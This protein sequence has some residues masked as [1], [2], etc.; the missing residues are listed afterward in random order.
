MRSCPACGSANG[1]NDDFCGNCGS[2]LGWSREPAGGAGADGQPDAGT[3][4][5]GAGSG[6][7]GPGPG[8]SGPGG[9]ASAPTAPAP[10]PAPAP[11]P[12]PTA[13]P[14]PPAV[15]PEVQG[16]MTGTSSGARTG[17]GAET[18]PGGAPAPETVPAAV[19]TPAPEPAPVL[20]VQPAKPVAQRPV[21]RPVTVEETPDGPPC[22]ACGTPNRPDRQFCR[23]CAARL[24][25]TA[26]AAA[27]PW[28]RTIWP[29]RRRVGN[30]SDGRWLRR[31]LLLL[32]VAGLL[33]AGFLLVPAGRYV[34]EDVRDKLGGTAAVG[35]ADVT[36]SA[37]AP[38]HPATA[39]TDGVT[40]TYWGTPALDASLTCTFHDP[41]RLVGVVVHTGAS[42]EPEVFRR[43]ARPTRAELRVTTADGDVD[44]RTLTFDDRPGRQ[45]FRMG[46]SEVVSVRLILRDAAGPVGE[47]PIALGEVEFFRRS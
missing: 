39:A 47:Q 29:L 43:T 25:T 8:G 26:P 10:G 20:P 41:F 37:E 27:L 16:P 36:A 14:T 22:P 13:P 34:V 15:P 6:G 40:N 21:V 42:K 32:V 18:G 3:G 11:A 12:A 38:G 1:D 4:S 23:R 46:I 17:T 35:T 44:T 19:P 30:G 7:P 31:T 45:E 33:V 2:Y 28:W 5:D 9:S 24:R